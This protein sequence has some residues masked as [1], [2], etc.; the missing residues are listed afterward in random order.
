M[1]VK[2]IVKEMVETRSIHA[3]DIRVLIAPGKGL[4]TDDGGNRVKFR[5]IGIIH[6]LTVL[7]I[8][9][10]HPYIKSMFDINLILV[11]QEMKAINGNMP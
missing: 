6:I 7:K 2:E 8:G 11:V 5:N 1:K 3:L 10:F 9:P 4:L